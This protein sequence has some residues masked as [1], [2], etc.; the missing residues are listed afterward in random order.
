MRDL[1]KSS[2]KHF[3]DRRSISR[4]IKLTENEEEK[5]R[6]KEIEELVKKAPPKEPR[7]NEDEE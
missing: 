7:R 2:F 1:G 4:G 6:L 5:R 3:V